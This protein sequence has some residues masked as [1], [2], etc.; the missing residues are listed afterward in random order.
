[1]KVMDDWGQL[2][3]RQEKKN[4][5]SRPNS[6]F[7]KDKIVFLRRWELKTIWKMVFHCSYSFHTFYWIYALYAFQLVINFLVNLGKLGMTAFANFDQL[8]M[9]DFGGWISRIPH[10]FCFIVSFILFF[11][12]CLRG[13]EDFFF[14]G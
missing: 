14:I 2:W 9:Y 7:S 3:I 1:M 4:L 10:T 5:K 12:W 6:Y 11:F 13:P 8:N